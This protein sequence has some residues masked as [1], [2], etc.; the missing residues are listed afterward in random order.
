MH[1]EKCQSDLKLAIA[2]DKSGGKT[3]P[4]GK[5]RLDFRDTVVE[6]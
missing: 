5:L 2:V 6:I 4:E 3:E 1:T